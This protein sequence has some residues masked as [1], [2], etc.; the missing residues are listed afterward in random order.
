MRTAEFS[1]NLLERS[2]IIQYQS[3][4]LVWYSKSG[5]M[6]IDFVTLGLPEYVNHKLTSIQ[7]LTYW[8]SGC[9]IKH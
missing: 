6:G 3:K 4:T 5:H 7:I 8:V 2:N 9:E 1:L